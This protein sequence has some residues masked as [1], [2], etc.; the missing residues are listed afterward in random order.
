MGTSTDIHDQKTANEQLEKMVAERTMELL[1]SNRELAISN[2]DL[3]LFA[4]VAS[5]DLKEP[6]RMVSNYLELLAKT[7]EGKLD[8]EQKEFMGYISSGAVRMNALISDLLNYSRVNRNPGPLQKL[9][10]NEIIKIIS[11][12]LATR[13]DE[14]HAKIKTSTLPVYTGIESQQIQLFQNLISN[15]IKFRH[16]DRNPVIE[17]SA[18]NKGDN[19]EFAI[20]DNGIG[21]PVKF[22][23]K[24]FEIF[25]R[26]NNSENSGT[27]IGLSI[28]KKVAELNG[29]KIWFESTQGKGSTFF[30][31]IPKTIVARETMEAA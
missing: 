18:Q 16:P 17:I 29:G 22:H 7:F 1:E 19:W 30:F 4:F 12:N 3:E 26:L 27:G 24:V 21:I 28:C 5:H 10:A 6:L 25:Q 14:T 15:A 11:Q 23:D 2:K 9:D 8:D 31:T 20:K 13:I